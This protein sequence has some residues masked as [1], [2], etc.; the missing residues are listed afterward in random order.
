LSETISWRIAVISTDQRLP[1]LASIFVSAVLLAACGG[2]DPVDAERY[3]DTDALVKQMSDNLANAGALRKIADIDHSRMGGEVGSPMPPTRVLIIS[4]PALESQLIRLKP[5]VAL[6]LPLRLLAFESPADG[7]AKVIYNS[8][9]YL[10]SRYQI[11]SEQTGD[12]R[13]SYEAIIAEVTKGIPKEAFTS[14]TSDQMQAD[15][16]VTIQS[17]FEFE[18]TL[19]RVSAAIDA[20]DDTVHF[21]VVDFQA[22]AK[23]QGI[24][25]PPSHMIL[26][27]APGP[28]GK[29]MAGAPT[30]GLD[31]FCQKFLVWQDKEGQTY[32]SF[33]DLLALAARQDV[34]KSIALRVIN[35]RLNKTFS[36]ALAA[37]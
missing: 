28:G 21:G 27:G 37:D 12:L 7:S 6:D 20:Q 15:G 23:E 19:E 25:I 24:D 17:P 35:F 5:L 8:F 10:V 34:S 18:E 3:A 11:N 22:D 13:Q 31:G 4:D 29:A 30:L 1:F 33:N 2:A 36:E 14:F 26:F 16:I 32:L 9:D